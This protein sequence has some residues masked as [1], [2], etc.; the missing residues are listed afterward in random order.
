MLYKKCVYNSKGI[1]LLPNIEFWRNIPKS[2]KKCFS[3]VKSDVKGGYEDLDLPQSNEPN[4]FDNSTDID[5]SY[6]SEIP[7][8][9]K[10]VEEFYEEI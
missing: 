10:K 3:F 9:M 1:E 5:E 6:A 7:S 2:I 4:P 8:K